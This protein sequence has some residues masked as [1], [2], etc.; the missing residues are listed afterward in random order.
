MAGTCHRRNRRGSSTNAYHTKGH[1]GFLT[2]TK[3]DDEFGRMTLV[4]VLFSIPQRPNGHCYLQV[5]GP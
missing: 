1:Q 2:N 5:W 3:L 4:R